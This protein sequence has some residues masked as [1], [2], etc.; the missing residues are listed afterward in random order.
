MGGITILGIVIA[1]FVTYGN[2]LQISSAQIGCAA[3]FPGLGMGLGYGKYF[4]DSICSQLNDQAV[5]SRSS[6]I[7]KRKYGTSLFLAKLCSF[8]I[9]FASCSVTH[10]INFAYSQGC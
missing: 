5:N 7:K 1:L 6:A 3:I 10:L 4:L 9:S 8:S 2:A